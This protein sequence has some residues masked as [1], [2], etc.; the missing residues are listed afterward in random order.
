MDQYIKTEYLK[1]H[2]NFNEAQYEIQCARAISSSVSEISD[3]IKKLRN[4]IQCKSRKCEKRAEVIGTS[5]QDKIKHNQQQKR[6]E[7]FG[8]PE[9]YEIKQMERKKYSI[10]GEIKRKMHTRYIQV[11]S[12]ISETGRISK[13]AELIKE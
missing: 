9:N 11:T 6:A 5:E 7:I 13:F 10:I 1:Q 4:K 8:T 12:K 3:T 2:S